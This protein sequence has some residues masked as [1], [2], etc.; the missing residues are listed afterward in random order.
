LVP[1][2]VL[3]LNYAAFE[4]TLFRVPGYIEGSYWRTSFDAFF[5]DQLFCYG[6]SVVLDFE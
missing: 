2:F 1:W 4:F 6:F 5:D 3:F